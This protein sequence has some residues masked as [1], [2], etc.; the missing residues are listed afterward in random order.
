MPV[1]LDHHRCQP[2]QRFAEHDADNI[3]LCYVCNEC[4]DQKLAQFRP[5]IKT[6]S[7]RH[8]GETIDEE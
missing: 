3:F 6:V 8:Y 7:S 1:N 4:R 5:D 2:G